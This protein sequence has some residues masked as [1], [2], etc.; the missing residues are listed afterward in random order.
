MSDYHAL[1]AKYPKWAHRRDVH[2][3]RRRKSRRRRRRRRART[4]VRPVQST[5]VTNVLLMQLLNQITGAQI[6]Q[7][8]TKH[9]SNVVS[10]YMGAVR[11]DR[12]APVRAQDDRGRILQQAGMRQMQEQMRAIPAIVL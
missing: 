7:P 4:R 12:L 6:V 3:A 2:R 10:G 8:S 9:G 1:R 5:D 11:P